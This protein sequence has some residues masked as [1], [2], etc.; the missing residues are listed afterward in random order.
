MSPVSIPFRMHD[1]SII[2]AP[3][4]QAWWCFWCSMFPAHDPTIPHSHKEENNRNAIFRLAHA[5][6]HLKFVLLTLVVVTMMGLVPPRFSSL[7]RWRSHRNDG[8]A[9]VYSHDIPYKIHHSNN[10][11]LDHREPLLLV[12]KKRGDVAHMFRFFFFAK[13]RSL[14]FVCAV[15]TVCSCYL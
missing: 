3:S 14:P 1:Q 12:R 15:F 11:R 10:N 8:H 6:P 13:R 9:V 7:G 4:N 2:N 5:A